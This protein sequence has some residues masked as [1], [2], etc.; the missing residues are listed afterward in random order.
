M[1]NSLLKD[2]IKIWLG[3]L[4]IIFF[5]CYFFIDTDPK[6]IRSGCDNKCASGSSYCYLHKPYRHSYSSSKR[7]SS[8]KGSSGSN[9]YSG[10]KNSSGSS[11]GSNTTSYGSA[12]KYNSSTSKKNSSTKKK[13]YQSYD[14]GYDDIYMND[15][16]DDYRYQYDSDYADGVDDAMDEFEEDW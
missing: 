4:S 1:N 16:Y 10:S 8:S 9:G 3:V 11:S 7:S 12:S 2:N 14:D 15:D 5:F 6:C 13:S